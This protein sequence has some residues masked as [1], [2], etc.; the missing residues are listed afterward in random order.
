[1]AW[2]AMGSATVGPTEHER[3]GLR[4]RRSLFVVEDVRAGDVVSAANV[5]SIR[6]AGGLAPEML[7]SLLGRTFTTDVERGTPLT[8]DVI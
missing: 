3:E 6:P 7:S 8:L 2:R 5:R 1:V 4:F